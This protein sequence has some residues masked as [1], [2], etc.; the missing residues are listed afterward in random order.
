MWGRVTKRKRVREREKKKEREGERE[1]DRER[2]KERLNAE[3]RYQPDLSETA[4]SNHGHHRYD[5]ANFRTK[6]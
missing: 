5:S 4:F 1:K 3:T 2:V 6:N